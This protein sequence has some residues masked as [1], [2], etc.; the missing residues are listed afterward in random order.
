MVPFAHYLYHAPKRSFPKGSKT[1]ARRALF[2]FA[3]AKTFTQHSESR[4]GAFIRDYLPV[5]EEIAG[6][7]SFT[8]ENAAEYVSRRTNFDLNTERLF[9]NNVDLALT[10]VQRRNGGKIQLATNLP[11]I[12]HIFPRSVLQDKE[13]EPQDVE[14]LGNLWILPRGLNRNKSA[15]HPRDFLEDVDDSVLRTAMID[16]DLLDY[17]SYRT[18]IKT[19]RANLA[20]KLREL[21][22]LSEKS[23]AF[24]DEETDLVAE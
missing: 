16:R 11:E 4:T 1:D 23:L 22:D 6:G 18:F 7:A 2:L 21:T 8:F 17:R 14:D 9:A 13:F 19:R 24:L 10:L 3:F 5:P 15:K 12:D 20:K